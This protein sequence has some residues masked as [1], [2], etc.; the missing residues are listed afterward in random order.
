MTDKRIKEPC[1]I[2]GTPANQIQIATIAKGLNKIK[3]P[4]CQLT[5]DHVCGKQELIDRW[6]C[7]Y[8]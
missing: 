8:R 7:R 4:N 2:C 1:P 5:F 3:C 6:N